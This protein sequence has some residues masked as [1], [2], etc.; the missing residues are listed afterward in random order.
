MQEL[1]E[2]KKMNPNRLAKQVV[3]FYET[4]NK[5]NTNTMEW[6]GEIKND[7]KLAGIIKA[8]HSKQNNFCIQ[9]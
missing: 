6:I 4:R 9:N 3:K 1:Y 2:H 7:L 5:P 8:N